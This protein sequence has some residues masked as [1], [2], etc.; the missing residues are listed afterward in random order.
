MASEDINYDPEEFGV[1]L[2]AFLKNHVAVQASSKNS[3]YVARFLSI[4]RQDPSVT[5]YAIADALLHIERV[6]DMMQ[7]YGEALSN[8][9]GSQAFMGIG[10]QSEQS[11]HEQGQ[12]K[13][14]QPPEVP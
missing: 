10:I 1:H 2:L 4:L 3:A 8:L 11:K 12:S 6:T 5:M 14:K 13:P 9:V 7:T